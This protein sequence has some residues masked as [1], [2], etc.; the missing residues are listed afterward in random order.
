MTDVLREFTQYVNFVKEAHEKKFK[1]R[2]GP[3]VRIFDKSTF[4]AVHPIWCACTILQ[5]PNLKEEIRKYGALTLLFHDILEDTS[6]KLP[7][8]LPNKVKKWVKEITFETHQESREKIW[9]KEPVIRLLK[10]YDS[11]NNLL[12]SFTW[13]TKE[14]K[15]G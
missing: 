15:R 10:L 9:K 8:D 1:K 3:Q 5:E 2:A 6:E 4:Y 11:T 7:K 14:K 12:D 13:Q